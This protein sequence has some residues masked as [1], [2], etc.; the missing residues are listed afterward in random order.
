MVAGKF[1]RIR[2]SGD[3]LERGSQYG[4]QARSQVLAARAGYE[5]SFAGAGLPWGEA[6][7][8]SERYLEPVRE[9]FPAQIAEMHGIADGAGIPF[10]DIFAMNCRTEILWTAFANRAGQAARRCG[11]ECSSFAL[12]PAR[13]SSGTT[14]V[15]Q[16]WDWLL[17]G[18]ESVVLLEVERH[19]GP[20]FVT[21]VEA[22][23]LAK[24]TLNSAGVGIAVN[25]LVSSLDNGQPGLPFHVLIRALADCRTAFDALE[26]LS[27]HFRASSGN[28]VVGSPGG[29]ILNIETAP[30]DTRTV[31]PLLADGGALVHT[32]HFLD[33]IVGGHDLAGSAMA[34]SFIRLQRMREL[35]AHP[36]TPATIGSLD[37][38]L[39]D[40]ID[41][42]GSI[43]CHPDPRSN[44]SER[45]STVMSVVMDLEQ[46]TLYL[47]EGN[48]CEAERQRL[49][50]GPLLAENSKPAAH[51]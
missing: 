23:L 16:N 51:V 10:D 41:Y 14:L 15:G 13:T 38:A 49:D 8:F 9:S 43:C 22:G 3:P 47:S 17:H 37:A 30:G 29:A 21:I 28:F 39:A 50:F 35:V 46:R 5:R 1:P 44:E 32:N 20:N 12:T 40:H 48:P 2:V 6:V 19:D 18:F 42:P 11:A 45:W 34:D 24:T 4:T 36:P 25:T 27:S 31:R 7:A 26:T 33:N